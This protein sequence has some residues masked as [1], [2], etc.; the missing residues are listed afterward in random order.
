MNVKRP[1]VLFLGTTILGIIV[2]NIEVPVFVK[3]LLT[4]I[5]I[6]LYA[7]LF[8]ENNINVKTCLIIILFFVIGFLRFRYEEY[9]FDK[10]TV[11]IKSLGK[12]YKDI[13]GIIESIGKSTNS[14]YYDLSNVVSDGKELGNIR[15]YFRDFYDAKIGNSIKANTRLFVLESPKNEG[16]FNQKDY[17]RSIDLS[18]TGFSRSIEVTNRKVNTIKQK[19]YEIKQ[20]IKEK[21]FSIFDESDAGLFS[22]M[23]TGDKSSIKPEIRKTFRDN[24]IAHILAIS[25]LH[26][27]ILG[28]ALFELL[29]KKFSVYFSAGFVSIFILFYG[30]FIDAGASSLRAICMLYVRFA[31]LSIGRTYDSKNTLYIICLIFLLL[32][33]Y[34]LFNAGFQFSYLA[35]FALNTDVYIGK[36][37]VPAVITLTLFLFPVT[38]FHYFTYPIYSIFLNLIVIPLMSFVLGFGLAGLGLS[39]IFIKL[40]KIV[41]YVVHLIFFLYNFL[42]EI[43]EKLPYHII[44]IGQPTLYEILFFYVA[45]FLVIYALKNQNKLRIILSVILVIMSIFILCIRTKTDF[46]MTFLS[47]GQGDSEVIECENMV[48]TID[49]GSTSDTSCGQYTITPHLKSRA[50]NT[51]DYAFISHADSDHTNG[52]SYILENEDEIK[53][54]NIVFPVNAETDSA[55]D[56]LKYLAT[57]SDINIMYLKRGDQ[58]VL[59]CEKS[60]IY[61]DTL[62]PDNSMIG[63]KKM[64]VNELSSVFNL[65]YERNDGKGFKTLFTGDVGKNGISNILS[66][67]KTSGFL[68]ANILKVPHHGSKNSCV[69]EFFEKVKANYSIISYGKDNSYGHPHDITIDELEKSRTKIYDTVHSGEI[70]I[71]FDDNINIKTYK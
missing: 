15:I 17:Y 65:K 41:A 8:F 36:R 39:F 28:L 63:M 46:R 6:F 13:T 1:T 48:I 54:H 49:G 27:S 47:I 19:I 32:H 25:G 7:K 34:L 50:I 67:E 43:I 37:K 42:C 29:R 18:A 11:N 60:K 62:S 30:I 68:D 14:D 52:I 59:K 26:L 71:Y 3:L 21:I 58:M 24:G 23:I 61:I 12:G 55:Y 44:N 2:A 66:D 9:K 10:F 69:P 20:I 64:D 38:V 53:V 4:M 22:A 51:I 45:V 31:A 33:P 5:A 16:E 35:I 40:G 70:D 56:K 57:S